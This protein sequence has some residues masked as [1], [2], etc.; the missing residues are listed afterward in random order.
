MDS[1]NETHEAQDS[2]AIENWEEAKAATAA[3]VQER[4]WEQFHAL[5]ELII[6]LNVEAGELLEQT[7]WA[8]RGTF[9]SDAIHEDGRRKAILDECADILFF[10]IRILDRMDAEPW[11]ILEQ[12]MQQNARKYPVE[13][14]RGRSDKYT[15]Y[16][17]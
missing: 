8:E 7:L 10:L 14:A 17:D 6:G 12:K 5:K 15:A 3:F 16:Q 2:V 4:D 13:R 9:E 1:K 11:K